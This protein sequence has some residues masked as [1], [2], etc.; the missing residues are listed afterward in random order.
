MKTIVFDLDGT[1][2][3]SAPDIHDA[4]N[5]FLADLG[6]APLSIET[7]IGFIGNGVPKL[8]ERVMKEAGIEQ[9]DAKHTELIAAFS[10][11]YAVN[12]ATLSYL[13][14]GALSALET[15][16]DA[17]HKMAVCTNKPYALTLQVLKCLK[18]DGYFDA[19]IGGDS[20]EVKK[21][22]PAPLFKAMEMLGQ[23]ACIYVGDS[24]V[25]AQTA[26]NA[27][28]PFFLFTDGYRKAAAEDL[29]AQ[30]VFDDFA[31]LQGLIGKSD[32]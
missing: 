6:I 11:H 17:G 2:V 20:L 27:K 8:V 25:D 14:K 5:K 26:Q 12:P 21:P 28:Q 18:I 7:I 32:A 29:N 24:E 30:A 4:A 19:V 15:L 13:N 3:E 23:D 22:D 16:R 1:L 9:T 31:E 10:A